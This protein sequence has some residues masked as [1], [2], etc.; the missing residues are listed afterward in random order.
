MT[1]GPKMMQQPD[2]CGAL[3]AAT[4]YHRNCDSRRAERASHIHEGM[5]AVA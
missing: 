3:R 1:K 2:E 5:Q 4:G